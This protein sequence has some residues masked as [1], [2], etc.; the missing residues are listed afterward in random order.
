VVVLVGAIESGEA[1]MCNWFENITQFKWCGPLVRLIDLVRPT[2]RAAYPDRQHRL[3]VL[4]RRHDW[5]HLQSSFCS[6]SFITIPNN[7]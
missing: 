2:E 1:G 7:I 5:L 4:L 3:F 6:P